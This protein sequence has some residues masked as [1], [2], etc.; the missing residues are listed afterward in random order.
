MDFKIFNVD[1]PDSVNLVKTHY[2]RPVKDVVQT[3]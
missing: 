2:F 1:G 3:K